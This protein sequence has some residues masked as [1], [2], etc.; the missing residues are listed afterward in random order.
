MDS[1]LTNALRS[2]ITIAAIA[3]FM[4]LA[5]K[6]FPSTKP[7]IKPPVMDEE[8]LEDRFL[9]LRGKIITGMILI[10]IL[11]GLLIYCSLVGLNRLLA[12]LDGPAQFR[13][14]PESAI[15]WFLPG[16]GAITLC[17][18]LT[19]QLW[20]LFVGHDLVDTFSNWTN[21]TTKFWGSG[22][23][24]GMDSRKVLRWIALL[25]VLPI[26]VFT[27]LALN[28]HATLDDNSIRVCGYA[29]KACSVHPYSDIRRM[30]AIRGSY[31]DKGQLRPGAGIVLDFS[32]GL[33]WSS[34]DWDSYRKA[35]D[36]RLVDL[37]LKKTDLAIGNADVE[38]DI[39]ALNSH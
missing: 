36:L 1:F 24:P 17:W 10:G 34:A 21:N 8:A 32:D 20:A 3:G 18:E 14:Y 23:Y 27:V 12:S 5:R 13:Y 38:K 19:L 9:P 4:A 11:V 7:G 22:S 16:F 26:G 6:L 2:T 37:L 15:W 33:R 35:Q 29:F 31:D 30:T 25:I 28:M 39:P